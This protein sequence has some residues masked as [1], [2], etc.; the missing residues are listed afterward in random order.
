M[1]KYD[2]DQVGA[3]VEELKQ[4]DGDTSWC[5]RITTQRTVGLSPSTRFRSLQDTRTALSP[6]PCDWLVL[7][8]FE[9]L[10]RL[11]SRRRAWG[12]GRRL[13]IGGHCSPTRARCDS[14]AKRP[15]QR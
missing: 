12:A 15:H 10:L 14:V 8:L 5:E 6:S 13:H 1:A 3:V 9:A 11:V 4:L 2:K 7:L